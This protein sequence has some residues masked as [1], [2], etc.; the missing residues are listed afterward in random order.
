MGFAAEE[1][2]RGSG[3]VGM[4]ARARAAGGTVSDG[5]AP[6]RGR[7]DLRSSFLSSRLV[8]DSQNSNSVSR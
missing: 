8:Y 7:L 5:L 3:L 4:R 2:T 6:G 1:P